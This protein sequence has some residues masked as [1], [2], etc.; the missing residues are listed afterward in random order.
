MVRIIEYLASY[1]AHNFFGT[2]MARRV[3]GQSAS[4]KSCVCLAFVQQASVKCAEGR[5]AHCQY[6]GQVLV[7]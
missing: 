5:A 3:G 4:S 7:L 6:E 2:W 1:S